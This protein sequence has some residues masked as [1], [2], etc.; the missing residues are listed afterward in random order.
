MYTT[1][2]VI[3]TNNDKNSQSSYVIFTLFKKLLEKL[4][5]IIKIL[6]VKLIKNTISKS[7]WSKAISV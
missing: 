7:W 5:Y 3:Q 4:I 6:E 2:F 1:V